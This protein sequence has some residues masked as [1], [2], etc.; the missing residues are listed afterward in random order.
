MTIHTWSPVQFAG[1]NGTAPFVLICEHAARVIPQELN[2]L[3]LDKT[4]LQSH[5]VWDIGALDVAK[6]LS[7][8]LNAP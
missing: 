8:T 2:G 7:E 3:G 5:A 1:T 4:A 6:R